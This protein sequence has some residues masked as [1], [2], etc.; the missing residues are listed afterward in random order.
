[1]PPGRS[2]TDRR[3]SG[4]WQR[5]RYVNTR[6]QHRQTTQRRI[7]DSIGDSVGH[8]SGGASVSHHS[9][10]VSVGYHSGGA[11]GRATTPIELLSPR[12]AGGI[13]DTTRRACSMLMSPFRSPVL[14]ASMLTSDLRVSAPSTASK[15]PPQLATTGEADSEAA[16]AAAFGWTSAPWRRKISGGAARTMAGLYRGVRGVKSAVWDDDSRAGGGGDAG[17]RSLVIDSSLRRRLSCST[18][19][20]SLYSGTAS[21]RVD[22]SFKRH[23]V[24]LPGPHVI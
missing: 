7:S 6:S 3:T 8:H 11:S 16:A 2:L 17:S 1:M 21:P 14:Q 24:S 4:I 22:A 13:L 9:G 23:G 15:V 18:S 10:G 20:S 5:L 19:A 12:V